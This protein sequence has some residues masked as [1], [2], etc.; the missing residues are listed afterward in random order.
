MITVAWISNSYCASSAP[1]SA[2]P[3][4]LGYVQRALPMMF[5]ALRTM[6]LLT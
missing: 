2:M 3:I 5:E 6:K 4:E 1:M